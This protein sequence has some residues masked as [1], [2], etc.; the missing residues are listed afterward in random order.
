MVIN[1]LR[2]GNTTAKKILVTYFL[3]FFNSCSNYKSKMLKEIDDLIIYIDNNIDS[4]KNIKNVNLIENKDNKSRNQEVKQWYTEDYSEF[5]NYTKHPSYD[6]LY[7]IYH[8]FQQGYDNNNLKKIDLWKNFVKKLGINN[9]G[10]RGFLQNLK[11]VNNELFNKNEI[12]ATCYISEELP[13]KINEAI[14]KEN[15]EF[16]TNK[17]QM[18]MGV[19]TKNRSISAHM[20]IFRNYQC[21][22]QYPRLSLGFHKEMMK[23]CKHNHK[24]LKFMITQPVGNMQRLMF[25][26]YRDGENQILWVNPTQFEDWYLLD[27]AHNEIKLK[28]DKE[29]N[30]DQEST[31]TINLLKKFTK[32]S[33]ISYINCLIYCFNTDI[34]YTKLIRNTFINEFNQNELLTNYKEYYEM[35]NSVNTQIE[36]LF[37]NHK[38]NDKKLVTGIIDKIYDLGNLRRLYQFK[39]KELEK[40]INDTE[41]NFTT[42]EFGIETTTLKRILNK[43]HNIKFEQNVYL[44]LMKFLSLHREITTKEIYI[45]KK[46]SICPLEFNYCASIAKVKNEEKQNET[47]S[48]YQRKKTKNEFSFPSY[49]KNHPFI[50][51]CHPNQPIVIIKVP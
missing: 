49:L 46:D 2:N 28:L 43:I 29:Q 9:G 27:L 6:N 31:N 23:V 8:P 7:C 16:L 51:D 30:I 21:I 34:S 14:K 5:Y 24:D 11:L 50:I 22:N 38:L 35:Y 33:L 13:E 19:F 47:V 12:F 4:N 44:K 39:G 45:K 25:Q 3:I 32:T 15:T 26:E 1:I 42:E 20:G 18:L 17:I 36:E 40:F 10:T 41:I 48:K 37:S